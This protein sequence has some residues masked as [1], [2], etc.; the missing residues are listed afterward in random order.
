[1][2]K[3]AFV[4]TLVGCAVG[5]AAYTLNLTSA[6]AARPVATRA[7]AAHPVVLELY[8]SQGCSSCPPANAVLNEIADRP[9]VLALNFA[10]TY[11][12]RLGWKDSFAQP[13]FTARQWDYA[14]AGG[15]TNVQTPQLIVDGKA[16]ILGSRKHEVEAAIANRKLA[17]G[18]PNIKSAGGRLMIGAGTGGTATVWLAAY[19]PRSVKVAVGTGEN[20][21]RT[22]VHR[23]IVKKLVKLGNWTGMKAQFDI[24]QSP[25]GTVQAVLVQRGAGGPI[26]AGRKL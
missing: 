12:D 16:A 8:Q 5:V 24:P 23:N 19:D 20:G 9:D 18:A 15:R 6:D 1:M 7:D 21:G 25:A 26:I 2:V 13:A 22:L 11:W 14:R 17:A 4:V 3:S 10:V